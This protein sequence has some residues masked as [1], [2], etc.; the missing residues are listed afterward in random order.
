MLTQ[1]KRSINKQDLEGN[2]RLRLTHSHLKNNLKQMQ[3]NGFE[4]S[5]QN[6]LYTSKIPMNNND[7]YS[8][9]QSEA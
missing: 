1:Q 3:V 5:V 6:N 7:A 4:V 8:S 9:K 2:R